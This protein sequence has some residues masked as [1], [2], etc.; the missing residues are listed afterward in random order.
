MTKPGFTWITPVLC[1]NDM[2]KSL[3]HYKDVLGFDITWTW[4]ESDAFDEPG[5][6]TFSCV[7]RGDYSL[8][9]CE[10]GQGTPGAWICLNVNTRDELS[11]LFDE[12]KNSGAEIVQDP[13]DEP[14]GMCEMVVKDMDG[15]VFRMGCSL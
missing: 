2:R 14:W 3:A 12:Y 8:F 13:T 7:T 15:N 4:S 9:L 11:Q 1:V 5:E 6:P 10:Q